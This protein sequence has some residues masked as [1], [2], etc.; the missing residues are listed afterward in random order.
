MWLDC[1]RFGGD[2]DWR[3]RDGFRGDGVRLEELLERRFWCRCFPCRERERDRERERWTM[4]SLLLQRN[5][6]GE[7][8][9]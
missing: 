4:P 3:R 9:G 1:G 2:G 7:K 6:R 5:Y 8:C